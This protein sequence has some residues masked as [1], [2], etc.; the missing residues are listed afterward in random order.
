MANKKVDLENLTWGQWFFKTPKLRK[1][2]GLKRRLKFLGGYDN[3]TPTYT[4]QQVVDIVQQVFPDTVQDLGE[5]IVGA[6]QK[7]TFSAGLDYIAHLK[8]DDNGM[9]KME[10]TW[11][12]QGPGL[13]RG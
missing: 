10:R 12:Y 5:D 8:K 2:L 1:A 3:D 4:K 6:V 11:D 7:I 9:Y 13:A